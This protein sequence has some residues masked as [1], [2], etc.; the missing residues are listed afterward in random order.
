M[1][2]PPK[3]KFELTVVHGREMRG[4]PAFEFCGRRSEA[5]GCLAT[6]G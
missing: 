5:S 6:I 2:H 1:Y 4:N 3:V